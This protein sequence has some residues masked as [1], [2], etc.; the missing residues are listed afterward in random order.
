MTSYDSDVI[1]GFFDEYG[2][3]EWERLDRTPTDRV[4]FEVHKRLLEEHVQA[5]DRVLEVG[6]GPGRFTLELAR[7]GARIV[8]GDVSARQ[9]DAHRERTN[10]VEPLIEDRVVLDVVDLSRFGDGEFDVAVCYG[11]P[12]S[13]VLERADDAVAELL[14]VTKP[15][16]RVLVSVMSMLGAARAFLGSFPELIERLGWDEAVGAVFE[17]GILTA[18]VNNG[19][20]MKLYR[21][22]ELEALL[23]RHPCRVLTASAANY[24]VIGN[25]ETFVQDERW[26]ELELAACREPGALD[27]G[28]HIVVAVERT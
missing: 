14:R 6:S 16:G 21:W 7:L 1:A 12:V 24:L 17:T 3:Q 15:G 23:A 13:Y 11:G 18:E 26:L 5:G 9:L 20:V 25:E 2:E 8:V 19:H 4:N 10:E 22:Q 28:T 27:A